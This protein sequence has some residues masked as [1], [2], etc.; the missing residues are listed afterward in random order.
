MKNNIIAVVGL[1]AGVFY[2]SPAQSTDT[3]QL[4]LTIDAA[5]RMA[6]QKNPELQSA[7][8]EV[9]R[10]DA[11]AMEAWGFTMPTV[12][13]S[14]NFNH[15]VEKP[16]SFFPDAIYYPLVK[17]MDSTARV[18]RPTGQ[19]IEL[20][21][22]MSPTNSANAA[23]NVRQI[24]FNG[25]VFIGV[26]AANIYSKLARDIFMLKK[27]ETVAKVRKA[28]YGALL[29][30]EA[31]TMMQSNL[32]NAEENFKNVQLLRS[33]GIVSEYDELRATVGMDNLR[34]AVIQSETNFNL[35]VD[36]LRNTIGIGDSVKV[37]P[38]ESLVFHDVDEQILQ[39][40][41]QAVLESNLNLN[42]MQHQ[43]ELN[44]ASVNAERANFLPSVIAYG[45]YSYTAIKDNYR[46]STNDFYKTAQVG[47][48]FSLNLF[49]GLQTNSRIE[50]AQLEE[51][52]TV[53]QK[54]SLEK[55][56]QM[57][58]RSVIGNLRQTR[59][60]ID[61][62]QKTVETAERGYKI[63]TAR[64][65]SNAATQLEVNDAQLALS[66]AKVNRM[67]AIYDYLVAA[68]EL[69]AMLGRLPEVARET[70]E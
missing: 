17:L 63:V 23:L 59:K 18:P 37:V 28:Y 67:Q 48:T 62:Q 55:N 11:R 64:F 9:K 32:K 41:D 15:I 30:H 42:V 53:E 35:A 26:G 58:I 13:L 29:A 60:R 66:Q 24:L 25:S 49:Q 44:G 61:G 68:S 40:A 10:S 38:A 36:N 2:A 14:G 52:K 51:Q 21:F 22:S 47:L 12:D 27:V 65:L 69:D 3:T 31:L 1:I 5:I 70:E 54:G 50:Q 4:S 43:I 20:P 46:F 57:G 33:Q 8:L 56:L 16:K 6:V 19:L 39:T 34:P 45:S 7:R